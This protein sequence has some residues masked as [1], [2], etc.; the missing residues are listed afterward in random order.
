MINNIKRLFC[1]LLLV[2]SYNEINAQSSINTIKA[3]VNNDKIVDTLIDKYNSGSNFA[4]NDVTIINGKT[5]EEFML[6]N[7]GCFCSFT[8]VIRVSD[9]LQ[10]DK[11]KAFLNVLKEKVV[12]QKK[13]TID[14]SLEWLISASFNNN[15]LDGHPYFSAIFN[16]KTAWKTHK[17]FIPE[18]YHIEITGDT[19]QKLDIEYKGSAVTENP[20]GFLVY[21]TNAHY[22]DDLDN[23]Q[24]VAKNKTYEIYKTPHTIYAK[25]GNTHKWLFISNEGLTGAPG[26]LRWYSINNVQ[27]VDNYVI[28]HQ[29]IPPVNEYVI[30]IVN[31]DTQRVGSLHFDASS[32]IGTDQEGMKTFE[33]KDEYLKFTNYGEE[34]I[35][36]IPLKKLFDSLD[37]Y[38]EKEEE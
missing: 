38:K 13:D 26:K 11:N 30:H 15:R 33:V 2:C 28:I 35:N 9:S 4:G 1:L 25:K 32:D 14:A 7:Y 6:S 24:P 17:P 8:K 3:D 36:K 23:E 31:I 19:L 37:N 21:Y 27:L 12:T 16:P 29:D 20:T 18:P 5:N 22:M 34:K 10:L